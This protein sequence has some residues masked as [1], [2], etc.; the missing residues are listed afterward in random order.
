[1]GGREVNV[2]FEASGPLAQVLDEFKRV[3]LKDLSQQ[4]LARN[5]RMTVREDAGEASDPAASLREKIV[6]VLSDG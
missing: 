6:E 2:E 5:V 3:F 4:D 1:M